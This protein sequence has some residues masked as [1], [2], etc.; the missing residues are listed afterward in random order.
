MFGRCGRKHEGKGGESKESKQNKGEF[1]ALL[2]VQDKSVCIMH[3][4]ADWGQVASG[5]GVLGG[6]QKI[7]CLIFMLNSARSL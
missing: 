6:Q 2:G 1:R 4:F 7:R 3:S 5:A